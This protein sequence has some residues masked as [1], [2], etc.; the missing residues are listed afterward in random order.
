LDV[1]GFKV[2]HDIKWLSQSNEKAKRGAFQSM[3]LIFSIQYTG[4]FFSHLSSVAFRVQRPYYTTYKIFIFDILE[5][6]LRKATKLLVGT[7][8]ALDYLDWNTGG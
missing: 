6:N 1:C 2:V 8:R 3:K 4:H 7:N 5:M